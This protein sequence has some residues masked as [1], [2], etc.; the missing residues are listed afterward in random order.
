MVDHRTF[1][2]QYLPNELLLHIFSSHRLL[3]NTSRRPLSVAWRWHTLAHVCQRWRHLIFASLRHL[4]ARLVI[5]RKSPETPLESWPEPPLSVW[6]DSNNPRM[7]KEQNAD[8]VA[9]FEHSD[10][11]REIHLPMTMGH[12]FWTSICNKSFLELEYL[13]LSGLRPN[14]LP[15]EFLGG[16]IPSPRRLRSILL[17]YVHLPAL[18]QLLLSSRDLVSLHLG[19]YSL[20]GNRSGDGFISPEVL[21]TALSSTTQ[22]E[23]LYLDSLQVP[24]TSHSELRS[25][26]SSLFIFPALTFFAFGGSV[27][28]LE[29]FVSRIHAPHLLNL[30]VH[31]NRRVL[32]VPQLSQFISRTEQLSSLPFRTSISLNI[33]AFSIEHHFR[34]LQSPQEVSHVYLGSVSMGDWQVSQVYHICTQLSPLVSS[35]K[36]LKLSAFY[37]PPNFQRQIDPALWLQLLAP[38][39]SVEEIEFCGK[40]APCTGIARALQQ[41]T[42]ETARELLPA[43]RVLR[44][45]GFRSR[46]IRLTMIFAAARRLTGRPVVV[47]RLN[48]TGQNTNWDTNDTYE[49]KSV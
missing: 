19:P 43:L 15:R 35:V 9:A 42:W 22:L 29:N 12:L 7:S 37:L 31:S 20:S 21:S 41:S 40:G 49:D 34:R 25:A 18:P 27:E 30:N 28:Y 10:R 24:V 26:D 6:Y 16:S 2:I 1:T 14:T 33:G 4:E 45:R 11:I 13:A 23:H 8:V 17:S 44:I 3:S 47:R 36:Q 32:D 46:S 39:N 48:E 5:P 38:Y